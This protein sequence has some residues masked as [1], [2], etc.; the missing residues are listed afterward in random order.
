MGRD[1]PISH[2]KLV[3]EFN[4]FGDIRCFYPCGAATQIE[5]RPLCFWSF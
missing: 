3:P 1:N 4:W 5:P 2:H